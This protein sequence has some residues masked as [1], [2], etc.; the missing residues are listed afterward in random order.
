MSAVAARLAR[1]GDPS[2][3]RHAA[4]LMV[5]RGDL[6]RQEAEVLAMV[7]ANPGLTFEELAE[8]EGA[9]LDKYAVARRLPA[10]AERGLVVAGEERKTC[11]GR[12]ARTWRARESQ[13]GLL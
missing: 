4:R 1:R 9:R 2:T 3:S 5:E 11:T 8:V 6:S 12:L 7:R 13:G 10:L